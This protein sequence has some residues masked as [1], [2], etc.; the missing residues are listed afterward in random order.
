MESSAIARPPA[1]GAI[2]EMSHASWNRAFLDTFC[3]ADVTTTADAG[4][5][6]KKIISTGGA[7]TVFALISVFAGLHARRATRIAE[8]ER[9]YTT[10][11][12]GHDYADAVSE[13]KTA[14]TLL[15]T[16]ANAP[17][18]LL[19]SGAATRQPAG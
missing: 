13:L 6:I 19:W 3:S 15:A 7:I 10:I 14:T 11:W 1:E 2:K 16:N 17:L 12:G 4:Q 9:A 5:K 8:G 18:E